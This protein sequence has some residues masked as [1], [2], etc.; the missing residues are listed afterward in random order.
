MTACSSAGKSTLLIYRVVP[1]ALLAN[2]STRASRRRHSRI[3][4]NL[5]GIGCGARPGLH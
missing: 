3:F 5:S 2:V 4:E 1:R